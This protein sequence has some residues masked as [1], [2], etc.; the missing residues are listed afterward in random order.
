M[1]FNKR[2]ATPAPNYSATIRAIADLV[3]AAENAINEEAS[4]GIGTPGSLS[5]KTGL[6]RNSNSVWMNGRPLAKD[7]E[8]ALAREVRFANDANCFAL[9]EAVDGAGKEACTI[10]GVIIGTG[11]GGGLVSEPMTRLGAMVT[12]VDASEAN[13]K[14]AIAPEGRL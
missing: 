13:I 7:I 11:C 10:F 9:S 12:A 3:S 14:T 8:G 1:L 2:I 5:P 6:L 4:I